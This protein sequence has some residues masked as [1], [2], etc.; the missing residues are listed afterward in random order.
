MDSTRFSGRAPQL[1]ATNGLPARSEAPCTAR[2]INSL[3]T[4][5]SPRIRIGIDDL[6]ARSPRRLTMVM[7]G[8]EPIISA[9]VMRP[10]AFFFRRSTSPFRSPRCRALRIETM[11]RSGDAGLTKKS[12]APACMAW[13]T[14]SMPPVAVSTTTGWAKPRPRSS[15]RVSSPPRPGMTRSSMIT[16][17]APPAVSRSIAASPFSACATA[18]PSRSSTA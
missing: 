17:A 7:A 16:S 15:F 12:C 3:P 5:L 8:D 6:A 11:I 10:P 14:V 18:K 9:K 1:T 4:P 2:A 13:T